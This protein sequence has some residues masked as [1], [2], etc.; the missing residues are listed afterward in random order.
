MST[1]RPRSNETLLVV[2]S[3]RLARLRDSLAVARHIAFE[4]RGNCQ[5][6]AVLYEGLDRLLTERPSDEGVPRPKDEV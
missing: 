3:R 5:T 4:N 1:S 2:L 6:C